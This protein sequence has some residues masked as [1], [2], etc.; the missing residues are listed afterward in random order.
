M[1]RAFILLTAFTVLLLSG[2]S[3]IDS[4]VEQIITNKSGILEHEDYLQY[5]QYKEEGKLD[6]DNQYIDPILNKDTTDTQVTPSGQVH[7]TFAENSYMEIRYYI[8]AT[9]TTPIDTAMCYLEPGDSLY[10]KVVSYRNPNSNLYRLAEFRIMEYNDDNSVKRVHCW[11][12]KDGLLEY[13]IPSDFTGTEISIV[14]VGKYSD[15][16]LSLSVYYVD[17]NGAEHILGNAG[18][19][20]VDGK[21]FDGTAAQISPIESYVLKFEYDKVN[22]FYVGCEPSCFTRDP[23]SSGFVEFQEANPTDE[24]ICYRVELHPYLALSLKFSEEAK[25]SVNGGEPETVKKSKSWNS[26]KLQYG[27]SIV[28]ETLG[29]CTIAGGDYRHISATK[30]PITKGYRYTLK[31]I[32]TTEGNTADILGTTV[33]VNRIFNVALDNTCRYGTCTYKLDG[34]IVS[35][36]IRV[37]EDQELTLTYKIT[38][39]NYKFADKSE[40]VGGFIHDLFK[41]T[42]RTVTIPITADLDGATIQPDDWFDIIEKGD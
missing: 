22:Y 23:A 4:R 16:T 18:I 36:E 15:R 9:M 24:D 21:R 28:I 5:L 42:E 40:G 2:C 10:G 35:G 3:A 29:E 37:R 19:W 30:D 41:A 39:K 34:D 31:V 25:V 32:R 12:A 7:I 27:D 20:Y 8:D 13:R 17:D 33:N 38:D 1:R 11:E 6:E 14:P 26:G